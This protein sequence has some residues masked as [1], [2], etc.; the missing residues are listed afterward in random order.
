MAPRGNTAGD[1]VGP[2][3]IR[4]KIIDIFLPLLILAAGFVG[5]YSLANWFLVARTGWLPLDQDVVTYWLPIALGVI[6]VG[7]LI[8]PRLR[9]LNLSEKRNIPLLYQV[10]A[11]ALLIVPTCIAQAYITTASG[12][13]MHVERADMIASAPRSKYYAATSVCADRQHPLVARQN[14]LSG[15]HNEYLDFKIYVLV[16]VCDTAGKPEWIG[17][18]YSDSTDSSATDAEKDAIYRAFAERSQHEYDGFDFGKVQYFEQLGRTSYRR[19]YESA[20]PKESRAAQPSP[21]ILIPHLDAFEDRNGDKLPWAFYSFAITAGV[22]LALLLI[23]SVNQEKLA[24][25]RLSRGA[26]KNNE[27]SFWLAL[28]IPRRDNYGLPIL[29]DI[30][31]AVY[32]AMV[33]SGL[34]VMSFRTDDLLAWGANYGP[35]VHGLGLYRLISSQ[36]IHGGIMHILSNL[37]GLFVAGLFLSPVIRKSGLIV[38]YLLC[39]LGGAVASLMTHPTTVSVGAS[40]AIMGLLGILLVLA[41]LG[42][43][44]IVAARSI[45]ITNCLIFA[46][47][48]LAQGAVE[49]GIDNA[50]HIGGL[51][52]GFVIALPM[53]W[54]SWGQPLEPVEKPQEDRGPLAAPP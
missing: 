51:V 14:E 24:E 35:D 33:F 20:I 30:N 42:D 36:F 4:Y 15:Q 40:G 32:L 26:R 23:P 37:Y 41:L 2:G 25:A 7:A 10:V 22:F 29:I 34:G 43:K 16:P 5:V 48:T 1:C 49:R 19:R 53:L 50:A 46:G 12:S 31:L 8:A 47:L 54:F 9:V 28:I 27:P 18:A 13:L 39:G 3:A 17:L 52:T 38:C 21:I 44:R 45:I 6:L 11:M